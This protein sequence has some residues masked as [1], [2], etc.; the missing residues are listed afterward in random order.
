MRDELRHT[1]TLAFG[2]GISSFLRIAYVVYAAR[3]LGP[4]AYADFY[5]VLAFVFLFAAGMA[6]IAG[7]VSRF[8]SLYLARSDLGALSGLLRFARAQI[9][10]IV[11]I[12]VIVSPVVV[13]ALERQLA[14]DS[15]LLSCL[16][17]AVLPLALLLDLPR[18]LLRGALRFTEFSVNISVEA[19]IRLGL[20]VVLLAR[21]ATA[22][23]AMLA[24]LIA[25]LLAWPFG[26]LQVRSIGRGAKPDSADGR[27]LRR[28]GANLFIV[29]FI[30]AALQNIDVLVARGFFPDLEAGLY[31]AASSLARVV[32]LIYLPFGVQLLPVLTARLADGRGSNRALAA[33]MS[34]F[35]ALALLAVA[36][37]SL[38][39][40]WVL[41]L[42]F[43][44]DYLAARPLIAPLGAAMVFALLS[45]LLGQAFTAMSSFKF[46]PFYLGGLVV[47][48]GI[49][50]WTRTSP[51]N[52][53]AGLLVSQV[54][55][56][57]VVLICYLATTRR[58]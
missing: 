54:L 36:I 20:S 50:W 32:G 40:E 52:L 3:V 51:A 26:E 42:L 29:A 48:M 34:A 58:V 7:T 30:G 44:A 27:M 53:A 11:A 37:I 8:T 31:S 9:W 12:L 46:I 19:V 15:R 28:F 33:I 1:L 6:P 35:G 10:R 45:I 49:L 25:A 4:A 21:A 41:G 5:A 17:A 57:G 39:G 16:A 56:F 18:G 2:T 43:G 24:Y 22:E 23:A 14:L 47:E 13:L 55:T 38:S